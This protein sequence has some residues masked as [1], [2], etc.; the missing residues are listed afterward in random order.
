[1]IVFDASALIAYLRDEKGADFVENLL[2]DADVEKV[3]HVV[4]LAEVFTSFSKSDDEPTARKALAILYEAGISERSEMDTALWQDAAGLVARQRNAGHGLSLGDSF[5]IALARRLGA[6]IVTSDR[7]EF[8]PIAAAG[9]AS[10]LF[11][12]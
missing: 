11:I 4:N 5:G 12:R 10:V 8:Q 6:D 2:D 3:A 1:M 7:A 9:L